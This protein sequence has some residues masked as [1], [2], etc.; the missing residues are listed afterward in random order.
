VR[1]PAPVAP[2]PTVTQEI[3]APVTADMPAVPIGPPRNGVG[4]GGSGGYRR[5]PGRD[6]GQ[7]GRQILL[8]AAVA[9]A[10]IVLAGVLF[11]LRDDGSGAD[12]ETGGNTTTTS[13]PSTTEPSTTPST[14][15]STTT[16]TE[17]P[18]T[19]TTEPPPVEVTDVTNLPAT[20]AQNALEAD[21]FTVTSVDEPSD[22]VDAG[23]V[24]RT[25]PAAGTEAEPGSPVTIFV[26]TGPEEV[27]VPGVI[28][29]EE[30]SAVSQIEA[31]GLVANPTATPV[32]DPTQEGL[33][34]DQN[35]AA[36]SSVPAGTT[37]DISI[38]AAP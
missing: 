5:P 8:L 10:V 20:D 4:G 31:A 21:G 16:S 19:T 9:A 12:T 14:E 29:A 3:R 23:N 22:T 36:D 28:G 7:R 26:S 34:L 33:V 15:P 25:D 24:I 37:V 11:T 2:E 30:G 6:D 13:Q 38:G 35:P 32:D 17:E 18:T 27:T 1:I